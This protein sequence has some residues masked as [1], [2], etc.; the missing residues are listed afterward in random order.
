MGNRLGVRITRN[1]AFCGVCIRAPD[2]WN[3]LYTYSTQHRRPDE[4]HGGTTE[5]ES[6]SG[7]AQSSELPREK[8]LSLP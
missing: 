2:F 5:E 1:Q 3:V 8:E 7:A 6:N 4:E